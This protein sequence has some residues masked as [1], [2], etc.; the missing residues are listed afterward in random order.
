M[1]IIS[2]TSYAAFCFEERILT[3]GGMEYN[4]CRC[5]SHLILTV[6]MIRQGIQTQKRGQH[7]VDLKV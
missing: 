1:N 6:E 4:S 2:F 7:K 5:H 3:V